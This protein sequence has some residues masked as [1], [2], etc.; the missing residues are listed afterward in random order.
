MSWEKILQSRAPAATLIV[1]L[2]VGGVFFLEGVKKFLFAE[3]WGA[4]RFTRIGIPAP[5][6]MGPFVG[7][8]E[9]VCGLFLLVGLLT[10]LASLPLIID[11]SV[12]IAS[13]K[14]PILLKSGFWPMEAEA[15]TDY[16]MLLGLIFLLI[17][18]AGTWS[19]DAWMASRRERRKG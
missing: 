10:R 1:R 14:V 3:Q 8:V 2:L 17:V 15:R 4:G 6:I 5:Q 13:T 7:V 19:L 12:A 11:I 16:S 18:G 9:I